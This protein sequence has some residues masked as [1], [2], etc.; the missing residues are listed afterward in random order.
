MNKT[1]P[2]TPLR[3]LGSELRI[4]DTIE[5][6]WVPNRDQIVSLEPYRGTYRDGI[7]K[8]ARVA[9]FAISKPGMTIEAGALF[10]VVARQ[11]A[12]A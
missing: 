4:G 9:G 3:L 7:L 11:G 1:P 8:G 6:W 12:S 5:T 10:N 2:K